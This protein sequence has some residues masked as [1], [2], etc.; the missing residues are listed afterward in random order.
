MPHQQRRQH[1]HRHP[2]ECVQQLPGPGPGEQGRQPPRAKAERGKP[3]GAG[4]AGPRNEPPLEWRR[5]LRTNAAHQQHGVQVD[6]RVEQREGRSLGQCSAA[7]QTRHALGRLE[8]M[9]LASTPQGPPTIEGQKRSARQGQCPGQS[10]T[11]S[12]RLRHAPHASG[13]EQGVSQ[14]AEQ[15]HAAHVFTP[16]PLAQHEGILRTNGHDQTQPQGQA[17]REGAERGRRTQVQEHGATSLPA[18]RGV[19]KPNLLGPLKIWS[20][21]M[22]RERRKPR[23]TTRQEEMPVVRAGVGLP[24]QR[25]PASRSS[26]LQPLALGCAL[27]EVVRQAL[28]SA[29]RR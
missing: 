28:R 7:P 19:D 22:K 9:D 10:R 11:V 3:Q 4:A 21:V 27:E 25:S 18:S 15:H 29:C 16:Q 12:Q 5:L 14:S 2:D 20:R 26:N 24:G 23:N 17:L 8:P 1:E 13:D 6:V